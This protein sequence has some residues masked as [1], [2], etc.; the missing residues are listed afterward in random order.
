MFKKIDLFFEGKYLCSTNQSKTCREA[1]DKYL[2]TTKDDL[3]K[4]YP[5]K[6]KA[7][8]DKERK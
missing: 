8:F 1:K 7:F 2:K 5:R 6:L 4:T 3:I